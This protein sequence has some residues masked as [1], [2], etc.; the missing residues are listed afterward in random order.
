MQEILL[1]PPK[2]TTPPNTIQVKNKLPHRLRWGLRQESIGF[3]L[4]ALA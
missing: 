1:L 3:S 2:L 4:N